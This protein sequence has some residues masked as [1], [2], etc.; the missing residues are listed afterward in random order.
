[1]TV[2][3][4]TH[5]PPQPDMPS[6]WPFVSGTRCP[7]MGPAFENRGRFEP[8]ICLVRLQYGDLDPTC[9]VLTSRA[10]LS[11]RAEPSKTD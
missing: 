1:M 10:P 6:F 3:R 7:N 2:R 8:K 11:G 4:E 9:H 5:T